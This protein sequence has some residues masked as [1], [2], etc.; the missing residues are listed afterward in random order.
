MLA[1]RFDWDW[2]T[3]TIEF[4]RALEL[5]PG[6]AGARQRYGWYLFA[7]GRH[8][9]SLA[10]LT[11]A[12]RD[13]PLSVYIHS[14]VGF[15][16]YYARRYDDARE[17]L[18]ETLDMD[19]NYLPTLVVLGWVCEQK[20]MFAEAI[21]IF[22]KA[23]AGSSGSPAHLGCLAHTYALAGETAEARRLLTDL[24][25]RSNREYVA[26]CWI[27]PAYAALGDAEQAFHWLERAYEERDGWLVY[28]KVDP[29]LEVLHLDSR[30]GAL[31]RR[32]G[33]TTEIVV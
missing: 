6:L 30:F 13:D 31:L 2:R 12:L 14:S 22:Q 3:A 18:A 29:R 9:D 1:W 28:T 32:I 15:A 26:P 23:I 17:H 20:A 7:L 25:A 21:S 19:S 27:A 11:R 33:L 10:Q 24:I 16:L 4:E 8:D 5:N